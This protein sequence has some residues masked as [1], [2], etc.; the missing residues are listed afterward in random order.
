MTQQNNCADTAHI[1]DTQRHT[2]PLHSLLLLVLLDK[3]TWREHL[4]QR[5]RVI[6]Q[7]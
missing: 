2:F 3:Q 7:T 5:E 6:K 1:G 4:S